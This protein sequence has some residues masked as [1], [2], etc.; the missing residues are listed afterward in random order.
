[1]KLSTKSSWVGFLLALSTLNIP[2]ANAVDNN[3]LQ[4]TVENRIDRITAAIRQKEEQLQD[5]SNIEA[6]RIAL[7]WSDANK[8][9]SW[10]D[11]RRGR[12]WG[13]G[14]NRNWVNG[15]RVNWKDGYGSS[16]TNINPWRNAWGDMG[17]FYNYPGGF[18][19][20]RPGGSWSNG[21]NFSNFRR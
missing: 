15:S 18:N 1:M 17:G 3:Q 12:G 20:S 19:N 2:T 8:N 9:R 7:S 21:S 4:P 11:T 5:T 6:D 10:L 13:D 16:F 14:N